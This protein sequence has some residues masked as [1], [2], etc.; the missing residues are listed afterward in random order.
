VSHELTATQIIG[1]LFVLTILIGMVIVASN[2][3]DIDWDEIE[4]HKDEKKP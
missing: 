1:I 4:S 3:E 2:I